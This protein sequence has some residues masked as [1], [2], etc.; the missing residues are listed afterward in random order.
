MTLPRKALGP[1]GVH[2]LLLQAAQSL[3]QLHKCFGCV[4]QGTGLLG[5]MDHICQGQSQCRQQ[6]AVPADMGGREVWGHSSESPPP[7]KGTRAY[8]DPPVNMHSVHTQG[9]GYGT[10]MLPTSSSKAGQHV[11]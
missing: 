7:A 10:S 2:T 3:V 4:R 11:G 5:F 9:P 8:A 6:P 1:Q